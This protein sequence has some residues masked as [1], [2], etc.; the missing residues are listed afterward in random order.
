MQ[1]PDN[2]IVFV[3]ANVWFSR[4]LRDWIGM[5]YTTPDNPPFEVRWT[6]DVLA[7]V[8]Y[9]LRRKHPDW[10]GSRITGIR[11]RLADTFEVRRVTDFAVGPDYKGRDVLDAHVHAA[12]IAC[13]ADILV[14]SNVAD[15]V[16]DG[17][18]SPYDVLTPD[19]FLMLVDDAAPEF[20]AEVALR[21]CKHW[22]RLTG[23]AHLPQ[24]LKDAGCPQFAGAVRQ[25]L[26]ANADQLQD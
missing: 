10:D 6:E 18:E 11:D 21:M 4:T 20:V 17:N 8:L 7:E 2:L 12:A 13:E 14:T 1:G 22:L 24:S 9:H 26:L 3:D 16:W 15:F 23:D 19:E 25:H 5:L